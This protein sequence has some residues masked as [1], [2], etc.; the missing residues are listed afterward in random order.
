VARR[1]DTSW[2][3]E[4][5]W[6]VGMATSERKSAN[7]VHIDTMNDRESSI[8][9]DRTSMLARSDIRRVERS[10]ATSA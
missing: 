8:A 9:W 6:S 3:M 4:L 5:K 10:F 7:L 2:W 1:S